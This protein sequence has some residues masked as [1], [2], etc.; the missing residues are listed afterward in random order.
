VV[1]TSVAGVGAR[2]D[3]RGDVRG[4]LQGF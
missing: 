4:D 1:R 3:E 2:E